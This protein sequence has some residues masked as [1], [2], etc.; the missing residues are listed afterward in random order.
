MKRNYYI[1][2]LFLVNLIFL[3]SVNATDLYNIDMNIVLDSNGNAKVKEM[4]DIKTSKFTSDTEI[5][6]SLYNLGNISVSDFSVE[7]DGKK[8]EF[9]SDWN[10]N[11][12]FEEKKYKNGY[13]Y[14][15]KGIELCFGIS[16]TGRKSYVMNYSLNNIIF[17]T[18]D[19]QVLYF[20]FVD[21]MSIMNDTR[22]NIV[23]S[24]PYIYPD[25]LDVWGFGSK[26][27]TYVKD[28]KI[29][30]SPEENT[31]L[32]DEDDYYVML[33][34][35]PL[36]TFNT[37]NTVSQYNTFNDVIEKSKEG[38]YEYNYDIDE[39]GSNFFD[40]I[41]GLI[42][43][44]FSFL[45][46]FL[47][48]KNS[49]KYKFGEAGSKINIKDV[50]MFRD[51]PCK[52]DVYRAYFIAQAYGLNSDK[53][54]FIGTLFLKWIS[55]DKISI[56]KEIKKKLF[57][58][59]EVTTLEFKENLEF[60]NS[61]EKEMYDMMI[62]ASKDGVLEEEEFTKYAKKHYNKVLKWFDNAES[63]GRSLY[64]NDGVVSKQKGKYFIND[65]VKNDAIE[66]AGL[67]K[68]LMEFATMDKKEAI[69]V[70]L[71]KEYLMFAQI[72]GIADRVAKQF[73][74]LYPEVLT[75]MNNYNF[76]ISDIIIL[77]SLSRN[78]VNAASSAR[79]AAQSYS[80]GGGGFNIGGGGGGSFGG[81]GGGSR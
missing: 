36:G 67:K 6:K 13:N 73:E 9:N 23:V 42:F 65:I 41:I 45:V 21:G 76:D 75:E 39:S 52:K 55:E 11:S 56:N 69:E 7:L 48:F 64:V 74:K 40:F 79:S 14:V 80:S 59:K 16:E 72:F 32:N 49:G 27:Y 2:F 37:N 17:N 71:W 77:N 26:G 28:G 19:A 54:D 57:K 58:D 33:V 22:Y 50:N 1:I 62:N 46:A 18:S 25:N 8:F 5:Y 29:Y 35:F 51:I 30:A 60:N 12:S 31:Y 81:G 70:K 24:G 63:Y 61:V 34:K 3:S 66:L 38:S 78:V 10:I 53:T 20:K 43:A 47:I 15:D 44:L 4:W 68:Y